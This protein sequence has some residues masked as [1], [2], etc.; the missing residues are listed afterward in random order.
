MR[1]AHSNLG[2]I[3]V[4]MGKHDEAL[5]YLD[6][7]IRMAPTFADAY[8][9]RGVDLANLERAHEAISSLRH[10]IALDPEYGNAYKNLATIYMRKG[11]R[12]SAQYFQ[13]L[14]RSAK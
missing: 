5:T 13:S 12:D 6:Q 2:V 14:A 10:A 3:K 11:M 7:A 8:L 9:N 4:R 1:E